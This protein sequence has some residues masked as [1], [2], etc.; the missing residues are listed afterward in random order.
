MSEANPFDRNSDLPDAAS[1]WYSGWGDFL[2][3][4]GER[5]SDTPDALVEATPNEPVAEA[6]STTTP[7]TDELPSVSDSDVWADW[8]TVTFPNAISVDALAT[9]TETEQQAKQTGETPAADE[10]NA[11]I[12]HWSVRTIPPNAGPVPTWGEPTS[13][14]DATPN[15][16]ELVS[17]IQELNQCNNTLLDRVSQLEEALDKSYQALEDERKRAAGAGVDSQEVAAIKEQI[18]QL[19]NELELSHQT[20]QRQQVLIENLSE[21]LTTSQERVAQ[22]ERE[23]A[24]VQQRYQEQAQLLGQSENSCRDLR[25]RLH[26]QQRYTMQFKAALE[27]CLEVPTAYSS[28]TPSDEAVSNPWQEQ[29]WGLLTAPLSPKVPQIQPWSSASGPAGVP[30]KLDALVG[31]SGDARVESAGSA[32][33]ANELDESVVSTSDDPSSDA[34][35]EAVGD[36]ERSVTPGGIMPTADPEQSSPLVSAE[37]QGELAS[38]AEALQAAASEL[39][40]VLESLLSDPPASDEAGA[41]EMALWHDLAKLVDVSTDEVVQAQAATDFSEFE[42]SVPTP[43]EA[44]SHSAIAPSLATPAPSASSSAESRPGVTMPFEAAASHTAPDPASSTPA[45]KPIAP[46]VAGTSP[47]PV[48]YPLRPA[49]KLESLAAVDLPNFPRG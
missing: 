45:S 10:V 7:Q 25:A 33:L 29:H 6:S 5:H 23:C 41:A 21:Q 20:N 47:A 28:E 12:P 2:D 31:R 46:F 32:P 3:E 38:S 11:D 14:N 30:I 13:S 37:M 44:A 19:F 36:A 4:R 40:S 22:L 8:Q 24:L 35:L 16:V 17:L 39:Q 15:L 49:K 18:T 43:P 9:Q 42:A 26:R 1:D 27:R 48:V 34:S